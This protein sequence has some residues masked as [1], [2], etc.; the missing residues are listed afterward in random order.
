MIDNV[1]RWFEI[2]KYDDRK[3]I[4]IANLVETMWLSRYPRSIEIMYDQGS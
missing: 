4:S 3:A 1:T 2:V